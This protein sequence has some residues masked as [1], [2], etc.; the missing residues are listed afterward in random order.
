MTAEE[1]PAASSGNLFGPQL[2]QALAAR[3]QGDL[4]RAIGEFRVLCTINPGHLGARCELAFTL[5]SS[6]DLDEAESLCLSVLEQD[7]RFA[8]ALA[9][10]GNVHRKRANIP[11]ALAYFERA[12]AASPGHAPTLAEVA[13]CLTSLS[14]IDEAEAVLYR[15]LDSDPKSRPALQGLAHAYS[16]VN[17]PFASLFFLRLL[18][19]ESPGD[20]A[21]RCE[22]G[23]SL[24]KLGRLED[25]ARA[26]REALTLAPAQPLPYRA[27]AHVARTQ[28]RPA[29]AIEILEQARLAASLD[30]E[31]LVQLSGAYRDTGQMAKAAEAAELALAHDP[32]NLTALMALGHVRR[33]AGDSAAA[34]EAFERAAVADPVAALPEAAVDF[35]ALGR[36]AEALGVLNRVI[37]I[38]PANLHASIQL[39]EISRAAADWPTCFRLCDDLMAAHPERVEPVAERCRVLI[40]CD[41]K[42]DAIDLARRS[43]EV[44]AGNPRRLALRL[45]VARACL[46]PAFAREAL[47]AAQDAAR[48]DLEVW[49]GVVATYLAMGDVAGAR[50]AL[51]R[52]PASNEPFAISRARALEAGLADLE[53]RLDDATRGFEASLAAN[54]TNPDANLNLARLAALRVDPE[55]SARRLAVF[56]AQ[57]ATDRALR[58]QSLRISQNLVGQL[59]N[60]L[61]TDVRLLSR[62]REATMGEAANVDDLIDI[63]SAYPHSTPA[64]LCLMLAL[65]TSGVLAKGAEP[66]GGLGI[67]AIP[68]AIM[69][70][71]PAGTP[72]APVQRGFALCRELNPAWRH[73]LHDA[74]SALAYARNHF[75]P[76]VQ[77]ACGRDIAAGQLGA[78]FRL[79]YLSREGGWFVD[80]ADRVA[81]PI[82]SALPPGASLGLFQ[83]GFAALSDAFL[84]CAPGEPVIARALALATAATNRGDADIPWLKTGP[85][86]VTRAFAQGLAEQGSSWPTWLKKRFVGDRV[87]FRDS[88]IAGY[89]AGRAPAEVADASP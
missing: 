74:E 40:A 9:C 29:E 69:Q 73:V 17:R 41:R 30:L 3:K 7:P 24:Q 83:D 52:S 8:S 36:V 58:G 16:V 49:L 50:T 38:D 59:L 14:R 37:A 53:W 6:G 89:V 66:H 23:F 12:A 72:P 81:G 60:E 84:G 76:D 1:T 20:F 13:W 88:R 71:W 43:A 2:E 45:E 32:D 51:E 70:Y 62:L 63:V 55:E 27:L 80:A 75:D 64:A 57:S 5:Y 33:A 48:D 44:G 35:R 4:E 26:F 15:V 54:P 19:E 47:A 61:K 85:G 67:P 28:K 68:Q 86:L 42:D 39:I 22:I 82:D 11:A 78:V 87:T 34:L 25:A 46:D 21:L 56:L 10:L 18:A 77:D 79:A 31:G 65:R